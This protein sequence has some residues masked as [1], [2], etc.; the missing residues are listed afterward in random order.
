[1]ATKVLEAQLVISGKDTSGPVFAGVI[2]HA[3]EMK[4]ALAG[5][6]QLKIGDPKFAE[7]SAEIK[8]LTALLKMERIAADEVNR[9]ILRGNEGLAARAGLL[10]RLHQRWKGLA[11]TASTAAMLA[12]PG[13]LHGAK[14]AMHAG[15]DIQSEK[16]KMKAAGIPQAEI[17]RAYS[18]SQGLHRQF[19][20]VTAAQGMERYKELRSVLLHPEETPHM[21]PSVVQAQAAMRA[22]DR[23]KDIGEG[24]IYAVK[25][26]EVLGLAQDPKRFEHYLDA[27]VRA[28]QVMGK[29]IT[30]EHLY[31]FAKYSKASGASLSDRFKMTT[32]VSLSQE[33][34]GSTAGVGVDQFVKQIV[35]GFQGSQHAAAKEFVALGLARKQD[36]ETTKTGEIKGFKPGRHVKGYALAQSDP[37]LWVYQYLKPALEKA[38]YNTLDKQ[39]GMVRRLY[40]SGRAADIVAKLLQQQQSFENHA[41][42]YGQAQGLE[43]TKTNA[44]DAFVALDTLNASLKNFAGTL[45]SPSMQSAAQTL[46]SWGHSVAG[47]SER[48][49][50]WQKKHPDEAKYLG[51]GA[52]GAG[53]AGGGALTYGL[54]S[55]L[56]SGF[57]LKGSAAALTGSAGALD[58]AAARLG[59][60][61]V[62]GAA[63]GAAAGGLGAGGAAAAVGLRAS[64]GKGGLLGLGMLGLDAI[65][66]DAERGNTTRTWLRDLLGIPDEGETAP[67]K[68]GGAWKPLPHF[69]T[70]D[71]Q[72]AIMG[73]QGPGL[74]GRYDNLHTLQSFPGLPM[75]P[76]KA[77][78]IGNAT[79]EGRITVEPSP[80]FIT[81]IETRINNAINAFRNSGAPASGT[82]GSTGPAMPE[83]GPRP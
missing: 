26:A 2:K 68:P 51:Y 19:P 27:F 22:I 66:R 46:D 70:D 24:L 7:A 4:K 73:P 75:E 83:T 16:V 3:N 13:I 78:I 25:A 71:V 33:V 80:D 32:G 42:L 50:E 1:M 52:M 58:A 49:S 36:F 60:S 40:P 76:A 64:M 20:N 12:G 21:L 79:L 47:I 63:G 5:T 43:A 54:L 67:W 44:D 18:Q 48:F 11:S 53:V 56:M 74:S 82:A 35:G 69:T 38:K 37:D 77:E 81:R 62:A 31:E 65:K 57:G 17:D 9:S 15:A 55:G 10:T 30:P 39:L 72:N 23:T 14:S 61:G 8:R 45:T 28:Q 41:K 59:A 6:A 29:T 34:G